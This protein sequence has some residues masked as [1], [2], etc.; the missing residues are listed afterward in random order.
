M[1]LFSLLFGGESIYIYSLEWRG[2]KA[3]YEQ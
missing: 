2:V 1:T 3:K